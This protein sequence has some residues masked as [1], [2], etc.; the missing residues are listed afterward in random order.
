MQLRVL[1]VALALTAMSLP[2][3][4]LDP[5][6]EH[7]L[8]RLDPATRFEQLC[9][10]EAMRRIRHDGHGYHP[11][12]AVADAISSPKSSGNVLKGNGAAFRSDGHWYH[13][14]FTCKSSPDHLKILSFDYHVDGVIPQAQ[15]A[16]Y[17][18]WQ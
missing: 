12:R 3:H 5:R 9:D 6:V 7:S 13:Y 4:A 10:V 17:G 11:D 15:W 1:M 18:L 16:N 14:D 8:Q 2:A